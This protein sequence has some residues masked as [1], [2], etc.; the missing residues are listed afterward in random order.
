MR[1]S[2]LLTLPLLLI[3][4]LH[5]RAAVY[6]VSPTGNDA[7]SGTSQ[8]QAWQTI[9]R[10][11]QVA[12]QL[13]PGDQVLFQ[14]G[15]LFRGK[16]TVTASGTDG[17]RITIGA[18]GTGDAPVISGSVVVTGWT[19][20]NGNIWRAPFTQAMKH[21]YVNGQLQTLARYPNTG[22]L[23][24]DL[25]TATTTQDAALTQ[26]AGYWTGATMVM[27]TANWSYDTARVTAHNGITLTHT[28]TGNNIGDDNWGYFLRNKLS[29]LDAPGE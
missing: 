15:G 2:H 9:A 28:S 17:N 21:L 20:H 10:V 3:T 14:R 1:A 13:Q 18:Y 6:F 24:N 25:G 12:G 22:W 8:S 23:R 19:V 7:N 16:L 5:L 29:E 11:N 27:R 26:P 4:G